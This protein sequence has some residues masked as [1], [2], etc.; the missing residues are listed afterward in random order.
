MVFLVVHVAVNHRADMWFFCILSPWHRL[1]F[2]AFVPELSAFWAEGGVSMIRW[3]SVLVYNLTQVGSYPLGTV[4]KGTDNNS[5]ER[6][7]H[8]R[9]GVKVDDGFVGIRFDGVCYRG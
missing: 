5:T 8:E 7:P 9:T 4:C 1:L 3:S 6:S 2:G